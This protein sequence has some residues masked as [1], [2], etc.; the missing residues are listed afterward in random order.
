MEGRGVIYQELNQALRRLV[1]HERF[2]TGERFLTEREVSSRYRVS[3]ATANK[4]LSTLVAEGVLEF[5][6]G[7]GT[8]VRGGGLEYDLRALVSFTDRARAAGRKPSTK[9][10]SRGFVPGG[11]LP[12]EAARAL[13][14]RAGER[15]V[16][17]ERL[18]LVDDLPV[19]LERRHV[20]ASLCPG[21]EKADLTG[22]LYALW[23]QRYRLKLGGAEQSIRAVGIGRADARLLRVLE[24]SAGLLVTSTGFLEDGAPLWF[25]RTLY[26]G[27]AYEFQNR[28]GG[29]RGSRP[30]V[31]T[32]L[33][34]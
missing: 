28:L 13:G 30:A 26:R 34:R 15:A 33:A 27:D 29:L 23:T 32:L 20:A 22:S 19:I 10:I 14:L 8:F 31:G 17:M 5:K 1:R 18:R 9:V 25:E 2:D 7:V 21:L 12:P 24:G 16:S 3:R 6:K 4:A 11:R